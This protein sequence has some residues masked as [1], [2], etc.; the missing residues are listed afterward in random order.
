MNVILKVTSWKEGIVI[1]PF[2]CKSNCFSSKLQN[3]NRALVFFCWDLPAWSNSNAIILDEFPRRESLCHAKGFCC[4]LTNPFCKWA[5]SL[6]GQTDPSALYI[7]GTELSHWMGASFKELLALSSSFHQKQLALLT[8]LSSPPQS[9]CCLN[10]L[11]F[12][13]LVHRRLVPWSW[14]EAKW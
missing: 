3:K 12:G 4:V 10:R 14:Q 11:L 9:V 8:A 7:P 2:Q 1:A 13:A 6:S 5:R